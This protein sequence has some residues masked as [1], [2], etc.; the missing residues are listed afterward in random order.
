MNLKMPYGISNYEELIT[1]N[2]QEFKE[3]SSRDGGLV[4]TLGK[5]KLF[6][7]IHD[8]ILPYIYIIFNK[9]F[10]F[11]LNVSPFQNRNKHGRSVPGL[12]ICRALSGLY[13]FPDYPIKN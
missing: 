1:E 11:Y 12:H 5:I 9:F 3:V 10:S 4:E 7:P 13:S 8:F 2:Y 6:S